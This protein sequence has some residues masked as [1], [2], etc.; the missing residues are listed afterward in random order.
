LR[1]VIRPFWGFVNLL[2]PDD[3]E[4]AIMSSLINTFGSCGGIFGPIIV[5][6]IHEKYDSYRPALFFLAVTELIATI[7]L[8]YC[9]AE[10]KYVGRISSKDKIKRAAIH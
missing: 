1:F 7:P 2:T 8:C 5:G 3:Q 4:A 6:Y 9:L 10:P